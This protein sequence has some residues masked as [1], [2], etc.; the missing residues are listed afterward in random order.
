MARRQPL[1]EVAFQAREGGLVECVRLPALFERFPPEGPRLEALQFHAW[2]FVTSGRCEHL[3]DFEQH[4]CRRGS[5]LHLGPGQVHRWDPRRGLDGFALLVGLSS[6]REPG[7]RASSAEVLELDEWPTHLELSP[8]ALAP[9]VTLLSRLA[10]LSEQRVARSAVARL[11]WHLS[12]ATLLEVANA[13]AVT[14]SPR[15]LSEAPVELRRVR[16][17]KALLERSFRQSR[18]ARWYAR[19]L[20]CSVRTLDRSCQ[21]WLGGPAKAHIDARVVLEARRRLAHSGVS[22]DVLA[23]ELGFTETTN[24]AKFF[25]RHVGL[26][27]GAFRSGYR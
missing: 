27:A 9:V 15:D 22:L 21:A 26:T 13:A 12:L 24:F 5:V 7:V 14:A 10:A 25:R 16:R 2:V 3:I 17:F 4:A 8:R 6:L 23:D 20:G 19:S 18:E 11:Q 1:L